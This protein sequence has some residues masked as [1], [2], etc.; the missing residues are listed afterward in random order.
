MNVESRETKAPPV[1]E[2]PGNGAGSY[3][4]DGGAQTTSTEGRK[5]PAWLRPALIGGGAIVVLLALIFGVRWLVYALAHQTTDDAQ[6]G[7]D[8]V[9][10]TS[11]IAERV[12]GIFT[13]T[14]QP[15]HKGQLLIQLDDRDERTK[16]EQAQAALNAQNAQVRAA[17]ENV[18]LTQAQQGAQNT[19]NS[20]GIAAAQAQIAN[21]EGQYANALQQLSV[22]RAAVPGAKASLDQ[23]NADL[24]RTQSLVGSGDAPRQ[25]LDA[26]RAVQ[27]NAA[28]NYQQAR[29]RVTAAQAQANAAK[30]LIT[31]SQGQ[32]QTAQGK[33]AESD[34]PYK[35]TTQ[36]AQA[37][38][39]QA[40]AGSLAA[41]LQQAKDS[42][43]YTQIHAPI[44][45]YVGEKVVEIGQTVQP[46][47]TL[48]NLV[49]NR[50]YVTANYKETQIGDMKPGQEVDIAVDA[51]KGTAFKGHVDAIGPA[52]QN[53][54]ALVPAQNATGNFVK[55]TQRV[56]VR[57]VVDN[58][59]A[60]KPLRPG[61]SVETSVKVK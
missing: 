43:S 2:G 35:V 32:L 13:D 38:A 49:P 9:V 53:Q 10:V 1:H 19:Q 61:M 60:D 30:A 58:P 28:A 41:Q 47:T 26:A 4:V 21:S 6:V 57:I 48:L 17:Q 50:T 40:Q 42:L 52:S 44:D 59:P 37:Q 14:N 45:G 22:A 25:Q 24:A 11:K 31:A 18:A 34:T 3:K 15:V 16:V 27:A 54:F 46:G 23:A 51:Y 5:R 33:L 55:V 12:A 8:T 7:A 39:Q 36:A 20:G 56:P 29:D